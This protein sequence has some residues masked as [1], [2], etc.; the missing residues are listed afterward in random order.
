[1]EAIEILK[2]FMPSDF[3]LENYKLIK[4]EKIKNNI[5]SEES[6]ILYPNR[7]FYYFEEKDIIPEWYLKKDLI[8]NW[9]TE[10]KEIYDMPL[11][12]NFLSVMIKRKRWLIKENKENLE[13]LE[14][15]W[16]NKN[17]ENKKV[18]SNDISIIENWTKNTKD[19]AF[20]LNSPLINFY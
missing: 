3:P 9:F 20:F 4:I 17:K 2:S 14:N 12:N 8:S 19:L 16:N 10:Y 13:N 11:R 1:M 5:W 7:L 6:K 18:I 15:L